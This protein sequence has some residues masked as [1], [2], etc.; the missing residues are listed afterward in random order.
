[1]AL[2][3]KDVSEECIVSSTNPTR[4][5]ELG[6]TL[7]VFLLSMLRFLVTANIVPISPNIVTLIVEDIRSTETSIPI[8][9]TQH[10]IQKNGVL[11]Q[12]SIFL[13]CSALSNERT[14]L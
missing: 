5:G 4:I 12:T 7:A 8:R 2:V 14:G 11:H 13:I 6:S 9:T 10:N 3:I 1:V